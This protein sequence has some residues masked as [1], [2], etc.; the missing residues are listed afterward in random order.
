MKVVNHRGR[1]LALVSNSSRQRNVG[2]PKHG[3]VCSHIE[4]QRDGKEGAY[5]FEVREGQQSERGPS[6]WCAIFGASTPGWPGFNL[7]GLSQKP[8]GL[9]P[10]RDTNTPLGGGGIVPGVPA[11]IFYF[12]FFFRQCGC[13]G[14]YSQKG[15]MI[16][17][18][19]AFVPTENED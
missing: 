5:R 11:I 8:A 16:R 15:N 18:V 4:Y 13:R 2:C 10:T 12:L 9:K 6:S 1:V 17:H 19:V 3:L 7:T 14:S